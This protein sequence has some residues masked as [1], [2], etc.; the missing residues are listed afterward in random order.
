MSHVVVGCDSNGVHD[1]KVQNTI[2]KALKKEGHTVEK[3]DI[4]PGPF[5]RYDWGEGG[6]NPKG[7][8][9]V[10]IIADGLTSISDRFDNPSG[11]KYVYFVIRGDLGR[12][13]MDSRKDFENNPIGK[14][15]EGDC[16]AKSCNRLVGKTFPQINKIVKKKC[17]IVFGT[18]AN[19][20]AD[21]LI[22]AMGGSSISN[23]D[24]T[25]KVSQGGTIK[26]A[27]QKLLTYW[28]GE[29]ECYIRGDEVHVNRVRHAQD[30]YSGVLV[31]SVNVFSDSVTVT[32]VNPN[33]CNYLEVIWTG[34]KIVI[35]DENLI[36]RFGVNKTSVIAN[37]KIKLD[38]NNKKL[39]SKKN[40][41][42][43]KKTN[44]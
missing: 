43:N 26:D 4:K 1:A 23:K 29:V 20:M 13:R 42:N 36:K 33:T 14:D 19:E 37:K 44:N 39:N 7:K 34:G 41:K 21:E 25:K 15:H 24:N 17:Y 22:K 28:D 12:K 18:T 6:K 40:K 3:L 35:K 30:Y 32:D 11:F 31:E 38:E 10:Y 8:I 27:L 9:G 16:T 5:G 2:V